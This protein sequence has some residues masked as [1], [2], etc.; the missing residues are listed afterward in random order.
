MFVEKAEAD[1]I[2]FERAL[3]ISSNGGS[4][5]ETIRTTS[6]PTPS[7]KRKCL[8][9]TLLTDATSDPTDETAQ[10][11]LRVRE[12]FQYVVTTLQL[13]ILVLSGRNT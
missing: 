7:T 13:S 10:L 12:W 8:D 4:S 2:S 11:S 9:E 6:I 3:Q 1:G 5:I